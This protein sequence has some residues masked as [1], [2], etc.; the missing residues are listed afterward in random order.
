MACLY[1][2]SHGYQQ[3]RA[4]QGVHLVVP[5]PPPHQAGEFQLGRPKLAPT[6]PA[7]PRSFPAAAGHPAPQVLQTAPE[8]RP[9]HSWCRNMANG[10]LLGTLDSAL[11]LPARQR[12]RCR[13]TPCS[14]CLSTNQAIL[15]PDFPHGFHTSTNQAARRGGAHQP[16]S[17]SVGSSRPSSATTKQSI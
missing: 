1:T 14:P 11:M 4:G 7:A 2:A 17:T 8:W 16:V 3:D 10:H 9:R 6:H 12:P 15:L 13:Y 5:S